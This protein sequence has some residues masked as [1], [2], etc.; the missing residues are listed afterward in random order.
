MTTQRSVTPELRSFALTL[1]FYSSSAYN[2]VRKKFNKCLPHPSTLRKWYTVVDGSPGITKESLVAIELKNDE[3]KSRGKNLICAMMLDEMCIKEDIHFNGKKNQGFIDFGM[4]MMEDCDNLPLAREALVI[5]LVALNSNWKIPIAYFLTNGLLGQEKANIVN[6]CLEA[7][8]QTGAKV[9]T[10]TFDGASSNIMMATKLGANLNISNCQPYFKHPITKE[11]IHIF[12][13]ACHMLKL[14]RNT[15]GDWKVFFDKNGD[16]IKWQFFKSL[17]ELQ[18]EKDLHLATKIRNRHINYH[19]EKMKVKLAAQVFSSSVADAIDY[20]KNIGL[21]EFSNSES[22]TF[23][24]RMINNIFDFLNTR[25]FLGQTEYKKPIK[26]DKETFVDEF[27]S[28]AIE[29]LKSLQ[30]KVWNKKE[31]KLNHI[32][33]IESKRKT[34]FLGLIICLTS[35]SNFFK[36]N[37]K[38]KEIDFLL[39]YKTSQDHLEMFFSLIRTRGGFNNNPTAS[40]FEAAYKRLIVHTELSQIATNSGTNCASQDSTS[41]LHVSS[42]NKANNICNNDDIFSFAEIE[43]DSELFNK[44]DNLYNDKYINDVIEYIAGVV[45]KKVTKVIKCSVC[46]SALMMD[47]QQNASLINIKSRGAL[48]KPNKNI[49][50]ICKIAEF[51]FRS[52]QHKIDIQKN[53][54]EFLTIKSISSIQITNYFNCLNEHIKTQDPLNHHT[55]QIIRLALKFYMTIRLHY[56]NKTKSEPVSR[57]RAVL[58]KA[59]HFRHQ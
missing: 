8:H 23:F 4:G 24:C 43:N 27:I 2:Y 16:A 51:T 37:I 34:G 57:I 15:L 41:I 50:E 45:T 33:I 12:Y 17:V 29:Y 47:I 3:M 20:S 36:E 39:T 26:L 49:A 7:V 55:S 56:L 11:N 30:T 32:P 25:N 38:T 44:F 19:K 52:F 28:T 22:T 1:N 6:L 54:I 5:M 48:T 31:N 21:K 40:Q 42:T 35:M 53:I 9:K 46:I 58:T 14:C 13:D 59:I 18:N 10:L